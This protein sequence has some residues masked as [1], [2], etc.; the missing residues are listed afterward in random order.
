MM[1]RDGMLEGYHQQ[2]LQKQQLQRLSRMVVLARMPPEGQRRSRPRQ[3][4]V[5]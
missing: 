3:R 1:L 4:V 5:M 2:Q